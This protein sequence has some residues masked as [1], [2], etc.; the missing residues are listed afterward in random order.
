MFQNKLKIKGETTYK[1]NVI[2]FEGYKN[3]TTNEIENAYPI[4]PQKGKII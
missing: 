4:L 1:G 2:K 3:L